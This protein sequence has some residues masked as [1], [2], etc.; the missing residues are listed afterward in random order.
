MGLAGG[1]GG[2]AMALSV[3][4]WPDAAATYYVVYRPEDL[5][6][7]SGVLL[8]GGQTWWALKGSVE[9]AIRRHAWRC[10]REAFEEELGGLRCLR[11]TLT[12]AG[13]SAYYLGYLRIELRDW[14]QDPIRG[15]WSSSGARFVGDLPVRVAVQGDELW[16]TEAVRLPDAAT[17]L[18]IYDSE[19]PPA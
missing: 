11:C 16:R 5:D 10:G 3:I 14:R 17:C 2:G 6:G 18:G 12:H 8:L 13:V 7:A 4:A 9:G 19:R 15:T 1:V